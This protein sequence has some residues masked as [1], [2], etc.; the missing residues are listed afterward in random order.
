LTVTLAGWALALTGRFHYDDLPNIVLDPATG[1]PSALLER[2]GNG[3]R[4][5]LRLSYA[6][7]FQL[8]GF[9]PAGFLA[10]NLVLHLLA[11][12]GVAALARP[13]LGNEIAVAG[14]AAIFA[15][16]PAHA[17]AIAWAS[18]RSTLLATALM[19]GAL[20]AH[21]R[22]THDRRWRAVSLAS[23]ALAVMTKEVA[24]IFPALLLVWEVTRAPAASARDVLRRIA[25]ATV[26]A[27]VL[28]IVAIAGSSRLRE[29]ILYS[30][31]LAG[32]V[33]T[34]AM[35][36]AA[37]PASLSLWLR[38]W[39]W[40][41]EQ[42]STF[43]SSEMW[44]GVC[45]LGAMVASAVLALRARRPLLALALLWPIVALLPTHSVLA[46][47][48]PITEKSLYLAWLGPSLALGAACAYAWNALPPRVRAPSAALCMLVLVGSCAWR[49]ST[50]A[51]PAAL[52]AEATVRM[53]QSSRAWTNRAL[54]EL[55]GPHPQ[56]AAQSIA[57]ALELAPADQQ[58]QNAALA[59][60]LASPNAKEEEP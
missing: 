19:I 24:L 49:A 46:R 35:N 10:T 33:D 47:L 21:E 15:L 52:W 41:I 8:W 16:Q 31:A 38:P 58:I 1:D 55:D 40:S 5:L 13:R 48:D 43:S 59:V 4:P 3:F 29:I 30:L 25:P 14:A 18:G 7:D 32:P 26:T 39:A 27:V 42:P 11:V 45:V 34:L 44:L 36:A 23:F 53:P 20:W 12:L 51:D 9:A 37:L 57:R 60:W 17:A 50:W 56:A 22:A 28:A 2:L 54:A 6:L